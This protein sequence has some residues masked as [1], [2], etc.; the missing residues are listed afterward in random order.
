MALHG[1]IFFVV[2]VVLVLCVWKF[3]WKMQ[4]MY[5]SSVLG[6]YTPDTF[7]VHDAER[8]EALVE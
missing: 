3:Y 5:N 1:M 6:L 8:H 4:L 2:L 7:P